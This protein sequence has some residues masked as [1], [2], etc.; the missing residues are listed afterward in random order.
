[1]DLRPQFVHAIHKH[2]VGLNFTDP[3]QR[4]VRGRSLFYPYTCTHNYLLTIASM[5][6]NKYV[7]FFETQIRYFGGLLSAYHLASISPYEEVHGT[8]S[9]L[10]TK[11]EELGEAML[12]A[13]NTTSGLPAWSVDTSRYARYKLL[14][15]DTTLS[16]VRPRI[17]TA[18]TQRGSTTSNKVAN[19]PRRNR[20]ESGRIQVLVSPNCQ[21]R[22]AH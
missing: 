6:Q 13:F 12:P 14:Y 1:M 10:K 19:Q 3:L 18:L 5:L 2:V 15:P 21:L 8:A 4:F 20:V 9:I 16:P 11:A 17:L 7:P 22:Q